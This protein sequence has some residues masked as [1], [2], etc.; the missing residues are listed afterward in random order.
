MAQSWA[1]TFYN[2]KAWIRVRHEVLRR[3]HYTCCN[4]YA[5]ASEVHHII[6]LTVSNI[7]NANI[8]L[9]PSNLISYCHDCHTKITMGNDG[10]IAAGYVFNDEGQAIRVSPP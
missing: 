10:D 5:R 9:N 7:D 3:D 2:S 1:K 4:C 6:P 8:S